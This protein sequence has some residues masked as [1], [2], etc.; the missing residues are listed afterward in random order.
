MLLRWSVLTAALAWVVACGEVS[1]SPI[2]APVTPT[3][4]L[5]VTLGGSGGGQVSSAPVGITCGGDC[6]EA[7]AVGTAVTLTAAADATSTFTGWSGGGCTGTGP[8]TITVTADTAV[9]ASFTVNNALDVTTDGTGMGTVV[10]SPGGIDCGSDCTEVYPSG[11]V[12]T[13]TAMAAASS[14]FVD[15]SGACSGPAPCTV[16]M[17]QARAVNATFELNRYALSVTRAG[18]GSG[19]VASSPAG[20]DCGA[21]CTEA[22]DHGTAVT[23]TATP[24]VGSTFVG[25]SGGGCTGTGAC[26]VTLTAVTSVTATFSINQ[27]SL[28]VMKAGNGNGTVTSSPAGISCGAD[29]GEIYN[30]GTVVTLTAAPASGSTFTGWSGGGCTGTGTCLTTVNGA[31]VVTATFTLTQHTLTVT[32]AGTGTGTVTSSPA[33]INCGADCTEVY[34]FGTTVTLSAAASSGHVFSGW[35]GGG[36]TGTGTCVVTINAATS[37]TATFTIPACTGS[38]TFDH[39]GAMQTFT[40]PACATSITVDA[41]GAEGGT[42]TGE[43]GGQNVAGGLGARARG[44]F[45]VT[46]GQIINVLVG[47][48][49]TNSNCGSG[50]GGGSF[51]VRGTAALLIAGG[52]GG[53]FHCNVLGAAVGTGGGIAGSNGGGGSCTMAPGFNRPPAPGGTMGQGGFSAF[54]GG[55]GGFLGAGTSTNDPMAGGG[56]YPGN[57]GNIGGGYGGGGGYYVFGC[58]GGSGGGGG[59][60]GGS[61]GMDDGC[62]GGGGGSINNGTNQTMTAGTRAGN[63]VVTITW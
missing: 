28:T 52:G 32:R 53:G 18:S 13:L 8:C 55:G 37:V 22:Y 17:D 29:C 30:F 54:G 34:N 4:T 56:M 38:Q 48:R 7:F 3:A 57:G 27:E 44:T 61:G 58:C 19:S 26:T 42:S 49:G 39:T 46:G 1:T 36:C 10:S 20:I 5:I 23:L 2:D 35:S 62:A 33:G 47:G 15:W 40:V 25:W 31:V 11:T 45:A 24:S 41:F 6:S 14:T 43:S 16:T 63:G 60:S 59:F 50:G 51:V 21:D 12:V 9:T